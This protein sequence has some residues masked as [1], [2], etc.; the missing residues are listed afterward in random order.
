MGQGAPVAGQEDVSGSLALYFGEAKA[1]EAGL[2]I[3]FPW[4]KGKLLAG[5]MAQR[6]RHLHS[7]RG[8]RAWV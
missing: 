3:C 5:E 8:L 7:L 4:T 1:L 6:V 2:L